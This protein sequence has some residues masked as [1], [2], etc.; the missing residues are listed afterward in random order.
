M[1]GSLSLVDEDD[2]EEEVVVV[3]DVSLSS[4]EL[5]VVLVVVVVG[6]SML[7]SPAPLSSAPI[8]NHT[9][10]SAWSVLLL[11]EEE[12]GVIHLLMSPARK[13][14]ERTTP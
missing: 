11:F 12:R 3:V 6:F 14:D 9:H 7:M 1:L 10:G 2:V 13:R 8:D 5:E 4:S